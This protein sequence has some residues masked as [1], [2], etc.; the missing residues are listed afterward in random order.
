MPSPL[1]KPHERPPVPMVSEQ[2]SRFRVIEVTLHLLR[3]ILGNLRLSLSGNANTAKR[4]ARMLNTLSELGLVWIRVAQTLTLHHPKLGSAQAE[5]ILELS[6]Q[7]HAYP[8]EY[9]KPHLEASLKRPLLSM[10]DEFDEKP[11]AATAVSQTHRAR[12]RANKVVVA[13]KIQHPNA[14]ERFS[15][16]LSLFNRLFAIFQRLGIMKSMRWVDLLHEFKQIQ[17]QELNYHYEASAITRLGQNLKNGHVQVPKVWEAYSSEQVLVM[18]FIRGALLSDVIAL[19]KLDPERVVAWL[20]A[21]Q[22]NLAV[23]AHRLFHSVYDQVFDHNY[24]HGH[25][26]TE[27]II[28]LRD[29]RMAFIDCR[30]S[31][32]LETESLSKQEVFLRELAKGEWV[33]AAE[34]YFLLASRLPQVDL[35][36]VK[37]TLIR[38]WR[39]WSAAAHVTTLPFRERSLGSLLGSMNGLLSRHRF[40]PQWSLSVLTKTWIHLDTCLIH[41]DPQFNYLKQLQLYFEKADARKTRR[42]IVELPQRLSESALALSDL[43]DRLQEYKLFQETLMRRQAQVVRGSSSKVEALLGAAFSLLGLLVAL[44]AIFLG[45]SFVAT[46]P[47]TQTAL[48]GGQLA[49]LAGQ[50]PPLNLFLKTGIILG[51]VFL[52]WLLRNE[53]NRFARGSTAPSSGGVL[54]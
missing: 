19:K 33:N 15:R 7:G 16:D 35:D 8:F 48:L 47:A 18:N 24:F 29:S 11:F 44:T 38:I 2:R 1:L 22:I 41:L 25:L 43:P 14:R 21:N 37:Q 42:A 39:L 45:L 28:L 32:S 54:S 51:L 52:Y 30:G 13:V 34:I 53:R 27:N 49:R 50:I 23:V 17:T 20:A 4:Q 26:T 40:A 36:R 5:A 3:L 6:G 12:L 31:G 10:F 46:D 9:I